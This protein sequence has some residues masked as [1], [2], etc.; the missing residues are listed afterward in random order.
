[1]LTVYRIA[2]GIVLAVLLGNIVMASKAQNSGVAIT[3]FVLAG[4]L[5]LAILG[6][7]LR[8]SRV[9]PTL[10]WVVVVCWEILFIWYAWFSPVAPFLFHEAHVLDAG[11]A[12]NESAAHYLKAGILFGLL[13]AWF[14]SLPFARMKWR[15]PAAHV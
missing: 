7:V 15:G 4:V 6:L 3:L 12:A 13:F 5:L 1:M 11:A 8:F 14:L 9:Q 10:F 2:Y